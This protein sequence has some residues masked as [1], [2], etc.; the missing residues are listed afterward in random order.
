MLCGS[1][2]VRKQDAV[3][4]WTPPP[5][6]CSTSVWFSLTYRGQL[7]VFAGRSITQEQN[8]QYEENREA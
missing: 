5:K 2:S 6:L 3:V 4:H 1:A 8:L 7:V